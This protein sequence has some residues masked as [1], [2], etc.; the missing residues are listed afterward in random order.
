MRIGTFSDCQI[1]YM[2]NTDKVKKSKQK[3]KALVLEET[4]RH[5]EVNERSPMVERIVSSSLGVQEAL[6]MSCD[7]SLSRDLAE[8]A[9]KLNELVGA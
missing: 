3:A 1:N 2:M 4:V 8:M 5:R 6:D 7:L 9:R